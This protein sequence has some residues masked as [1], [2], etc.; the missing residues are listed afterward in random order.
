MA[1]RVNIDFSDFEFWLT[2]VG[3]KNAEKAVEAISTQL[4]VKGPYWTGEFERNWE[5]TLGEPVPGDK[6]REDDRSIKEIIE[7][8]PRPRE[9][10]VLKAG[11]DFPEAPDSEEITYSIANRMEYREIAQDLIPEPPRIKGGGNETADQD[12]YRTYLKSGLKTTLSLAI[13][14]VAKDPTIKNFKGDLNK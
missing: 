3:K 4:K 2:R 11:R 12:W 6:P 1:K 14:R 9:I 13:K 10:T 7:D 8:G 5:I